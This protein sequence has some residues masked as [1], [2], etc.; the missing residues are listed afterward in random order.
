[1]NHL[2]IAH[3]N[4]NSIR[5]KF[6]PLSKWV[7]GNL[8][9][10]VI[11]ETKIDSSFSW[12]QF[13]IEGYTQYRFNRDCLGRGV[14]IYIREDIP[15]RELKNHPQSIHLEGIFLE[16]NLRKSKWL[17]FGGYNPKKSNI[18]TFLGYVG[19]VLDY[20][21]QYLDIVCFTISCGKRIKMN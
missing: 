18:D 6:Q 20:Y 11:T 3:L 12:K 14:I 1:M 17:L 8:D 10:C 2:T 5:N 4:I 19:E 13:D 9:I 16:I 7:K 21:M 15:Y